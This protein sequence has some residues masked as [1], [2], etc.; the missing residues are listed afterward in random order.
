MAAI[1]LDLNIDPVMPSRKDFRIGCIGSGMIMRD[2]HLVAYRDAGFNPVAIASRTFENAQAAAELRGIPKVHRSWEALVEDP[3]IEILDIALPPDRQLDVVR[4]AAKQP[5]IK[6]ILCQKPL[7]MNS[8]EAREIVRLCEEAGIKIAVNSNMRYD[9]SIRGLKTVLERG[10]LGEPVLATIE[11]RAIPH[12]QEFLRKYDRI[13]ILNMGIHHIDTFRYLFGD[14]EK[15]TAVTRRDPRTAFKHIDGISQYTFQYANELMATSLDDV[16]AWPGEGTEKDIYIKWRVV[17]T[18][19]LAQGYIG[20]P[21]PE[22]T[23]STLEF[24]TRQAPNEWFRPTWDKVWF[25]DAFQGTMGQ[26]L[27]A[28]ESDAEPEIGG[29]DNLKTMAAVDACYLSIAEGRT[30]AFSEVAGSI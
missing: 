29:R 15:I 11:M 10:Y 6:G 24:T 22:R 3:D 9:Q 5:H 20:W 12:W 14:P 25:P 26:L 4:L 7:A 21:Y 23:P 13:E 18:D 2:C 19:G 28:V 8:A 1:D 30:V 27:R 16:W 17:G